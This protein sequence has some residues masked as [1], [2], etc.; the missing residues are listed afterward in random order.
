[1]SEQQFDT[2]PVWTH[3]HSTLTKPTTIRVEPSFKDELGRV[4]I[5]IGD[6][7]TTAGTWKGSHRG[8]WLNESALAELRQALDAT[9]AWSGPH[10]EV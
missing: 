10:S 2:R 6:W 9:E 1:M 5:G 8:I 7:D 3:T 4:F